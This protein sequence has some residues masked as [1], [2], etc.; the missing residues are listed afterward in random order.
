MLIQIDAAQLEW[1]AAVWLS[2]DQTGLQEINEKRD[3][4]T[5]NQKA[6]NLPDRDTA[7]RYLFRTIFRGSGW[8]FAHDADFMHVST[9]TAFWD[10]VNE[11]FYKKYWGLDQWHHKLAQIVAAR[12]P[13]ISPTG[14]EWLIPMKED[15]SIPWTTLSNYPVQGTSAD[16][17]MVARITLMRRLRAIPEL[18]MVRLVSTVHDSIVL[19]APSETVEQTAQ[20]AVSCFDDIPKNFKKLWNVDLPIAFPGEVKAGPNL[21]D[22]SRL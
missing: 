3:A 17:V 13:I 16:I 5:D 18:H 15:G 2:Q 22:L 14:R 11:K 6:F 21:K 12:K 7:K 19:D 10:G 4:H 8:S 9:S 20:L 1:R